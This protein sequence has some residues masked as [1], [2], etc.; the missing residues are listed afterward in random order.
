MESL[1]ESPVEIEEQEMLHDYLDVPGY[2]E[3][4]KESTTGTY[5]AD[6]AITGYYCW[7]W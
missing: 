2:R 7:C 6:H 3:F 5:Q 1:L 4:I